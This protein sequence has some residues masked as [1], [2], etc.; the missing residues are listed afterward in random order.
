MF[1]CVLGDGSLGMKDWCNEFCF[2][3]WIGFQDGFL[4][5]IT[6]IFNQVEIQ[7]V[8]WSLDHLDLLPL[9]QSLNIASMH[10]R[11]LSCMDVSDI[12]VLQKVSEIEWGQS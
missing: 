3:G 7:T 12:S 11:V 4:Y 1:C 2:I 10:T 5:V 6:K 8:G 9:Q